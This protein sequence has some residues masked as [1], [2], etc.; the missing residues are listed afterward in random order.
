MALSTLELNRIAD[1]I[2][3]AELNFY[4]H[5]GSPG[6]DGTAN[7][8]RETATTL[9]ATNWSDAADG[10][11]AYNACLLYTSPSPRDS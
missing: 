11:V 8:A 10:D 6:A 3:A 2:V 9:A 4:V 1:D 5:T 7:R